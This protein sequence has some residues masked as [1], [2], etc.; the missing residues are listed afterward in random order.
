MVEVVGESRDIIGSE[1]VPP[2]GL[3]EV[4]RSSGFMERAVI[5]L[6]RVIVPSSYPHFRIPLPIRSDRN[7][8]LYTV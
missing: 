2:I 6:S 3:M 7:R 8:L 1:N 4:A 5:G